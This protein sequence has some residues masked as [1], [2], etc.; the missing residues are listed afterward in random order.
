LPLPKLRI[1][2][3]FKITVL[4]IVL[5]FV[6]FGQ[7]NE[8]DLLERFVACDTSLTNFEVMDLIHTYKS[9]LKPKDADHLFEKLQRLAKDS[10]FEEIETVCLQILNENPLSFTA[11]TY[12][13]IS[14]LELGK[15]NNLKSSRNKSR[16]IYKAV[17]KFGSGKES[18]PYYIGNLSDAKTMIFFYWQDGVEIDSIVQSE[19][20]VSNIYITNAKKKNEIVSFDFFELASIRDVYFDYHRDFQYYSAESK[21]PES[22]YNYNTLLKRFEAEDKMLKNSEIIALMIGFTS[23]QNYFPYKNISIERKIMDLASKKDYHK[24]LKLCDDF[25][26]TNPLSFTAIME[27]GY[28]LMKIKNDK[29]QFPSLKSRMLVDAILWSGNGSFLSPYFVLSPIDGQTIIS[30]I[31]SGNIG[32]MGSANDTNGYFLDILEI[33]KEGQKPRNIYFN[34]DHATNVLMKQIEKAID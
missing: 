16:M 11:N 28:C 14:L 32:N 12:Y 20:K 25:L 9:S 8:S 21:K 3:K 17:K 1:M 23:N 22:K 4:L 7:S 27:K 13:T 5:N 19:N 34:I 29:S 2:I 18:S 24:S 15:M 10:L 30:Y 6:G 31:F 26:I 33:Q